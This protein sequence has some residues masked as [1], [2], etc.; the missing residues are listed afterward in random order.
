[1]IGD[2]P[3]G[4]QELNAVVNPEGIYLAVGE[5]P[6]LLLDPAEVDKL[7]LLLQAAAL[8]YRE[9]FVAWGPVSGRKQ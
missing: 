3:K 7:V 6:L 8:N 2:S 1:M 4:R 9:H 5:R